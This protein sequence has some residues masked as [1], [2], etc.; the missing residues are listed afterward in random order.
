MN[1]PL[2][3][4]ARLLAA[5]V[6]RVA[7]GPLVVDLAT[8][9]IFDG[10]AR[11]LRLTPKAMGVLRVL[12]DHE[13]TP[14]HRDLLIEKVW[15]RQFPT[16]DVVTKAVRELRRA[17]GESDEH[18]VIATL[19]KVGYLLK[20]PVVALPEI[21]DPLIEGVATQSAGSASSAPAADTARVPPPAVAELLAT[22][23]TTA[24]PAAPQAAPQSAPQA[25]PQAKPGSRRSAAVLAGTA[26]SMVAAALLWRFWP[27]EDA[28]LR[29]LPLSAAV[30]G[31]GAA[32]STPPS[33]APRLDVLP[34]TADPGDEGAP[35]ISADGKLVA[36]TSR[37]R[38][39]NNY[40]I[41]IRSTDGL[42]ERRLTTSEEDVE[43]LQPQF[44]PD[45]HQLAF[46]VI[47]AAQRCSLHL[48]DLNGGSPRRLSDCAPGFLVPMEFS[49]DGRYILLPRIGRF[50]P[51]QT[52][53]QQLEL[54]TGTLSDYPY[55][56]DDFWADVEGR[57][58]PD[59]RQL[60]IRRGA[61]PNSHLLLYSVGSKTPPRLLSGMTGLIRGVTW[62]NDSRNLVFATDASGVMELWRMDVHSGLTERF[63]GVHGYFPAAA[64]GAAILVTQQILR[65]SALVKVELD[66][67]PDTR[68]SA[69]FGSTRS[70]SWPAFSPDGTRLA[71][72]S[73][74]TGSSQ[75]YLGTLDAAGG[76]T[77]EV[78]QLTQFPAGRPLAL[79]FAPDGRRIAF[80]LRTL[81][82]S[83][84]GIL[85]IDARRVRM[86]ETPGL[87]EPGRLY[88]AHD[89]SLVFDAVYADTRRQL[90]RL[91]VDPA[92]AR[93]PEA[94]GDCAGRMG[95]TVAS[96][97]LYFL[98][99]DYNGMYVQ[100]PGQR[101]CRLLTDA[102]QW[103]TMDNWVARSEGP[104]AALMDGESTG[105]FR[106]D[107]E[108]GKASLIE[109]LNMEWTS[110]A[111]VAVSPD[112]KTA[113]VTAPIDEQ[114]DLLLVR[115]F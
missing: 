99:A 10:D 107:P 20:L 92:T 106:I 44:A 38:D 96:G 68:R 51:G 66:G 7:I 4:P 11:R 60:L 17:L 105:L 84:I 104:I 114:G 103:S 5:S 57:F 15:P 90:Y 74:R 48:V 69:L 55:P 31:G 12:I 100:D 2:P 94:I 63:G 33:L 9:E 23:A 8:H 32:P 25:A 39:S 87:R 21:R 35:D 59:G 56:A 61:A 28:G 30:T 82:G 49:V 58:S 37:R 88:F 112:G 101:D 71:F 93:T 34:F 40:R 79:D 52:G 26:L 62:L 22:S 111:G 78:S 13:G 3:D 43:E 72:V 102:I 97:R 73:D 108:N 95:K 110:A 113:V 64:S 89:G 91:P 45:G 24:P 47:D 76:N 75:I 109:P 36:Y 65:P 67:R 29:P 86:L 53:L 81:S 16:D 85:E 115:G 83:Q 1:A 70:E 77:G 50:R 46:Q 41:Y 42:S 19:P 18:P 54:A 14:V 27:P 80:S 98:G 6:R